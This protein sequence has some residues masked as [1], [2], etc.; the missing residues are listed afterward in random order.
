MLEENRRRARLPDLSYD[1]DGDGTV[2]GR[3]YFLAKR[4]DLDHDG[5]LN[6]QEKRNALS[7]L[8][9]GYEDRFSWG[10]EK[11]G[12]LRGLR[13]RQVRGKVVD[14]ED[15]RAVGD[16]YPVHP[17]QAESKREAQTISRLKEE[18]HREL[19]YRTMR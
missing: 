16:T 13:I 2:G 7:A 10:V 1:L 8:R 6:T 3:D 19:V 17:L 18:R 15:Y 11:A 5:R 9:E 4:F 14:A 12:V